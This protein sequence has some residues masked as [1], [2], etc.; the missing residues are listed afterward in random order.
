MDSSGIHYS[1]EFELEEW[2]TM[3][4]ALLYVSQ[5]L[6]SRLSGQHDAELESSLSMMLTTLIMDSGGIETLN[7]I[8][9]KIAQRGLEE[10][11]NR[12]T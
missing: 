12:G 3:S 9:H 7:I 4:G 10:A 11:R 1:M 2:M 5:L 6:D 8:G